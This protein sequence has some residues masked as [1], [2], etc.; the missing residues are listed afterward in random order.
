MSASINPLH[1]LQRKGRTALNGW[2]A[3]PSVITAQAI[4][5]ARWDSLTVDLQHGTAD[6]SD[7]LTLLPIIES[8]GAAPLVRVPW[9]DEGKVMRVLDAGA[10]GIIA[11]MVE[12]AA[13]AAHL[14]QMCNYPPVGGRSF[15]PVRARMAWPE[16]FSTGS[17][18]ASILT[19]AMIE[20]REGVEALDEIVGV[21]GLS[22]I[23]IGPADLG[24]SHGYPA[25]FDPDAEELI[26]IIKLIRKKTADAG[27]MCGLHC[28]T[29]SYA[30]RAA[31]WGMD[32][33]TVGSDARFVESGA[34]EA[35]RAF[36][37]S[38]PTE[39]GVSG[40]Y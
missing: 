21:E 11:P 30:R 17:A 16:E 40:G 23:Y 25:K 35:V 2:I 31:G 1:R 39:G 6:Y 32:L 18:N 29:A 9:L 22:G 26:E 24:L 7:L 36:R 34:S 27:L 12:C 37:E 8:S 20:T 19:F 3:A 4:A 10:L 14:V 28:G 38:E 33:V 15:G 5:M 13:D